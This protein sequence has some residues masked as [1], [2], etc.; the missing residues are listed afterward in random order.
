[1][2][3]HRATDD[4]NGGILGPLSHQVEV[5][6]Y[7]LGDGGHEGRGEIQAGPLRQLG[8][9]ERIT[10]RAQVLELML[11]RIKAITQHGRIVIAQRRLVA[12]ARDQRVLVALPAVG[13]ADVAPLIGDLEAQLPELAIVSLRIIAHVGQLRTH[14]AARPG[15]DPERDACS[16]WRPSNATESATVTSSGEASP[17]SEPGGD[18]GSAV[19]RIHQSSADRLNA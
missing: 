9:G 15:I 10:D 12:K 8:R 19:C 13:L 16:P 14:L 5:A 4:E 2:S 3:S 18:H 11:G 6:A 1:M 7:L 17:L